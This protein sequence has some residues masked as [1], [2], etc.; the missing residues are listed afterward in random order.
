M[1]TLSDIVSVTITSNSRGISRKS[2]GIPLVVAKH[3]HTP[4]LTKVYNLG[5]ALAVKGK[6][7]ASIEHLSAAV[8]IDPALGIAHN[9]LGVALAAK[10]ELDAAIEHHNVALRLGPDHSNAHYNLGCAPALK[11]RQSD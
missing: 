5:T 6:L 1:P 7:D 4:G 9:N 8:R 10:G 11:D 3:I 2:F